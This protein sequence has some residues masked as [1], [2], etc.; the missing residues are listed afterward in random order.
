MSNL[1]TELS[2]DKVIDHEGGEAFVQELNSYLL[3]YWPLND[4]SVF[5]LLF[6][7]LV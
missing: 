7:N 1:M 5:V 3:Y 6:F 4:L 2:K